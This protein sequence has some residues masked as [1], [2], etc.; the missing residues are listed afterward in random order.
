MVDVL[1]LIGACADVIQDWEVTRQPGGVVIRVRSRD[2]YDSSHAATHAGYALIERVT[3]PGYEVVAEP[4]VRSRPDETA[5]DGRW[6]A[7]AELVLRRV[8]AVRLPDHPA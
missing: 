8:P 4:T 3:A 5:R 2:S 7:W 6:H 1:H